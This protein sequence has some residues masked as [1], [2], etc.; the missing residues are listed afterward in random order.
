MMS[1]ISLSFIMAFMAACVARPG[2]GPQSL[3][4][5]MVCA[6]QV[7]CTGFQKTIRHLLQSMNHH[8]HLVPL[9]SQTISSLT[10]L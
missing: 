2:S 6:A 5:H 8:N 10:S 1:L 3:I 9:V 4:E 7:C